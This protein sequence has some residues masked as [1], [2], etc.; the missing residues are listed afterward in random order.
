MTWMFADDKEKQL[1]IQI[2]DYSL[3]NQGL[4]EEENQELADKLK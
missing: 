2:I 4:S 1:A 3:I